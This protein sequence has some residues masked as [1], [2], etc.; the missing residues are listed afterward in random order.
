MILRI[1]QITR[2][3]L[4]AGR[5]CWA[6]IVLL[7]S[8]APLNA[9]ES[10][11]DLRSQLRGVALFHGFSIKRLDL[12]DNTPAKELSGEVREQLKILLSDY[13]YV[14]LEETD[15]LIKSVKV[16][17]RSEPDTEV[18]RVREDIL[19]VTTTRRGGH[20]LV[21]AVLVGPAEIPQI[22]SLIVDTGAS[23]VVLPESLIEPLG[24]FAGELRHTSAQTANGK[25]NAKIGRL[26]SVTLDSAIAY[27]VPVMFISDERLGGNK[28]L[29]MSF[30]DRFRFTIDDANSQIILTTD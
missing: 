23:T 14:V 18:P 17:G 2:L 19:T 25:V 21:Q 28:L 1:W 12:V 29:G 15:G 7:V 30:L 22:T 9:Q 11:G 5:W 6:M 24:F 10:V 13:S 16:L 3:S 20:H 4:G 8:T 27:D 26:K